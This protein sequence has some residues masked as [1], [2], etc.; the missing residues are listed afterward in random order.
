MSSVFCHLYNPA[1]VVS[2]TVGEEEVS[3]VDYQEPRGTAESQA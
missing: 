2:M 1:E 3:G